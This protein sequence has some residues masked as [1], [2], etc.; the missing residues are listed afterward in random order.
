MFDPDGNAI[1]HLS[2]PGALNAIGDVN[3]GADTGA[4]HH[5]A[6]SCSGHDAMRKK[7]DRLL[8]DSR[9][10]PGLEFKVLAGDAFEV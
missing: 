5:V 6:L 10:V 2:T 1:F 8:L 3:S 4:V 7:L 9:K